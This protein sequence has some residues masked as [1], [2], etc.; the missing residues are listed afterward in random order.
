MGRGTYL[1]SRW[2]EGRI[3]RAR[4]REGR[5][6]R[7][8]FILILGVGG[9]NGGE[10][11]GEGAVEYPGLFKGGLFCKKSQAET[12]NLHFVRDQDQVPSKMRTP[13]SGKGGGGGGGVDFLEAETGF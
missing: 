11:G 5:H 7:G 8:Q 9:N 4:I 2:R 3:G 13:L 1:G 6:G 12:K 10:G